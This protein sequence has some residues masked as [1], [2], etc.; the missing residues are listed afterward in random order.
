MFSA[1]SAATTTPKNAPILNPRVHCRRSAAETSS[2]RINAML[3]GLANTLIPSKHGRHHVRARRQQPAR[4][5]R[6]PRLL[7]RRTD[8]LLVTP[9]VI[10]KQDDG[11]DEE[12]RPELH[13]VDRHERD[14]QEGEREDQRA[15][16]M[17]A[18][19]QEGV[20]AQKTGRH[21]Q[22]VQHEEAVGA[23]QP[24]EGRRKQRI[25]VGL[26]EEQ[27]RVAAPLEEQ[28]LGTRGELLPHARRDRR[29]DTRSRNRSRGCGRACNKSRHHRR[30]RR[31]RP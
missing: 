9:E 22:R 8:G 13:H 3:V 19:G 18:R 15:D 2:G 27:L 20:R 7:G 6:R 16:R 29:V 10:A 21:Q 1:K 5:P 26:R 4:V 14:E 17:A 24:D 31:P 12:V 30:S 28:T 25:D 23:E 11:K